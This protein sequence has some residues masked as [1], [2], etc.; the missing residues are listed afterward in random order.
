M[1]IAECALNWL[2]WLQ[3]K[4][5]GLTDLQLRMYEYWLNVLLKETTDYDNV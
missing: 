3:I 2:D 5:G 4:N 1:S